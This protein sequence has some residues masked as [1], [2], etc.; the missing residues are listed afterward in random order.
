M[1]ALQRA[2]PAQRAQDLFAGAMRVGRDH[3][4]ATVNTLAFAYAG[5][6]LPLLLL[7]YTQDASLGTTINR[8]AVAT[9]IVAMLV[10]SIGL[11]AAVPLT[12]FLASLLVSR[13]PSDLLPQTDNGHSH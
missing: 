8:E 13:L 7:F 11:V 3:L 9:E 2:N 1:I 5:A 10:G 4:G 12:T 6:A